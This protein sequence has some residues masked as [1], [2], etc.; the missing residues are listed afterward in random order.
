V[1][2]IAQRLDKLPAEHVISIEEAFE[3]LLHLF[4]ES[5]EQKVEA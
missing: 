5:P 2:W 4:E 1:G 3:R